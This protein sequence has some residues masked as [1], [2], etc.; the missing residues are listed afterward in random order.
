MKNLMKSIVYAISVILIF[1]S[2]KTYRDLENL[3]PKSSAEVKKGPFDRSSL[4]KLVAG[5]KI[6]VFTSSGISYQMTFIDSTEEHVKGTLTN[7]D[8][9]E[10]L[11]GEVKEI[12]IDEIETLYVRRVSAAATAPLVI[13]GA[14][15]IVIGI[16]AATAEAYW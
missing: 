11:E 4:N 1:T 5:D 6:K 7:M 3:N 14:L 12:P 13:F 16:Y 10:V 8:S 15:G 2:C 9:E